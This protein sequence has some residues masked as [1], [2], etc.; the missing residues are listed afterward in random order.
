MC[1]KVFS[2]I[3]PHESI[4]T[5]LLRS[6][7]MTFSSPSSLS[8]SPSSFWRTEPSEACILPLRYTYTPDNNFFILSAG[9]QTQDLEQARQTI[10]H[11]TTYS[12]S[13]DF[14]NCQIINWHMFVHHWSW[15]AYWYL[16][17]FRNYSFKLA[18]SLAF[19]VS[20]DLSLHGHSLT[21]VCPGF[22]LWLCYS[23]SW[24]SVSSQEFFFF[25]RGLCAVTKASLQNQKL[26]EP[27]DFQ[28]P[29]LDSEES[30]SSCR[31]SGTG[32][33][34]GWMELTLNSNSSFPCFR[35]Q[36]TE[37]GKTVVH[38]DCTLWCCPMF[39]FSVSP[40]S[41]CSYDSL[42]FAA[43][44]ELTAGTHYHIRAL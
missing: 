43:L 33:L 5:A 30:I 35:I 15:L 6:P 16:A 2:W 40:V 37:G 12:I 26:S 27:L 19:L 24:P 13:K 23:T 1:F 8:S 41:T 14:L 28:Q 9:D 36:T 17:S 32:P 38:K 7:M 10:Y 25:L 29:S 34:E 18:I 39:H 44:C 22:C 11:W 3:P 42:V 31:S 20:S 4:Q 21:L